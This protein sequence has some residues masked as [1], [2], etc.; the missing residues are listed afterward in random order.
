MCIFLIDTF[1]LI[2]A[3]ANLDAIFVNL[4]FCPTDLS[5]FNTKNIAINGS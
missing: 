5:S 1:I 3:D 4:S 2:F